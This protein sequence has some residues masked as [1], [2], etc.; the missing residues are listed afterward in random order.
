MKKACKV[1]TTYFGNRRFYPTNAAQTLDL[2]HKMLSKEKTTDAGIEC[3]T[4]LVNHLLKDGSDGE[5]VDLLDSLDGT[6]LINGT[7]I[8]MHRPYDNG[9]GFGFKSRDNAFKKYQSEYDY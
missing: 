6:K 1:V 5:G 7:L 8:V 2:F 3:D 4:I 9:T